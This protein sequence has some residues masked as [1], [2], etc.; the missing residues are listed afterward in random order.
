MTIADFLRA[1]I[2]E[3]EAAA[4]AAQT[5]QLGPNPEWAVI[6][7]DREGIIVYERRDEAERALEFTP[8]PELP[9]A[10]WTSAITRHI[11]RHSPARVLAEAAAKRA[12][13][14]GF[15]DQTRYYGK[16]A[17]E[18]HSWAEDEGRGESL[19]FACCALATIYADHPD[20]NPD[21]RV[22]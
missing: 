11:E 6:N 12:I 2:A 21:W 18:E 3:D 1:R 4:R 5:E 15:I 13:V 7:A 16:E 17:G 20:Y 9:P 8:V 19:W 22:E 10:G 14:E